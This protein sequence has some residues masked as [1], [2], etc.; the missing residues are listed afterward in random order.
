M[1]KHYRLRDYDFK[2]VFLILAV[3]VIGIGIVGS[4]KESLQAR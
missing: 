1:F 4:A 3:S 2:L